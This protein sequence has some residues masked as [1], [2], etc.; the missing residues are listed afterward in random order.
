M[1]ST[2]WRLLPP[3]THGPQADTMFDSQPTFIFTYTFED[4]TPLHLW[5]GDRWNAHGP[6]GVSNASYVSLGGLGGAAAAAVRCC[7]C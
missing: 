3:P 1:C 5:M 6:G 2:F 4:G 7:A